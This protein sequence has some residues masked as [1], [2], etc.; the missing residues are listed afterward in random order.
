[1]RTPAQIISAVSRLGGKLEP[2][3]N[4]LRILLPADCSPELKREIR[5]HKDQLLAVLESTTTR[6]L[7][8]AQWLCVAMQVLK[9]EF[10]G[11]DCAMVNH[12]ASKLTGIP[13]PVCERALRCLRQKQI[14]TVD[15]KTIKRDIT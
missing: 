8:S 10:V 13:D 6:R 7:G 1:M 12:L 15:G 4:K 2:V 11:A 14:T 3:G 9:G 5:Q